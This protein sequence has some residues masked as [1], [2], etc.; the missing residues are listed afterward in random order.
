MGLSLVLILLSCFSLYGQDLLFDNLETNETPLDNDAKS[1]IDSLKVNG[2]SLTYSE[3]LAIN[4]FILDLKG[5]GS[6]TNNTDV[7]NST[8][9]MY[10]FIGG[11]AATHALNARN[12]GT[13]DAT[14]QGTLTHDSS[15]VSGWGASNYIKTGYTPSTHGSLNNSHASFYSQTDN[16]A[17]QIA[18]GSRNTVTGD[19][20]D[21]S[22]SG[23]NQWGSRMYS[24]TALSTIGLSNSLG[25]FIAT[26]PDI[27][28]HRVF[29][30]GV[31]SNSTGAQTGGLSNYE[32]FL[33]SVNIDG[34]PFGSFPLL[35][36][37]SFFS[38][39][40]GLTDNQA[41]DYYDA[42]QKLQ[43]AF[44]RNQ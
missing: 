11:L 39:G 25:H 6:T 7:W 29:I 28:N 34:S 9:V 17:I 1:Y 2:A 33:G 15:G 32:V 41:Q 37:C 8:E 43:T 36:T 16:S 21:G 22:T 12:L 26:R 13:F 3:E 23:T 4:D 24:L 40:T 18:Y 42:V 30:D 35:M 27:N 14:Y 10:P 19:Y 5:L 38:L 31:L 44:G 20:F